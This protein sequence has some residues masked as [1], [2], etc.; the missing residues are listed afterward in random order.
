MSL[1]RRW[2]VAVVVLIV[3][4][5]LYVSRDQQ[6]KEGPRVSQTEVQGG[7][8]PRTQ[9]T[10]VRSEADREA[11]VAVAPSVAGPTL[12]QSVVE[13][14]IPE[15]DDDVYVTGTVVDPQGTPV[16]GALVRFVPVDEDMEK[17]SGAVQGM[18]MAM[19][20]MGYI[21]HET[22]TMASM[23]QGRSRGVITQA[24]GRFKVRW[25][26]KSPTDGNNS[27]R[28]GFGPR[29]NSMGTAAVVITGDAAMGELLSLDQWS[30]CP[31][32]KAPLILRSAHSSFLPV[33]REVKP[34]DE[35]TMTLMA[36]GGVRCHVQ[37]ATGRPLVGVSVRPEPKGFNMR[38]IM[39]TSQSD[40]FGVCI[41]LLPAGPTTLTFED[42]KHAPAK[43]EINVPDEGLTDVTVAMSEGVF[44]TGTLVSAGGGAVNGAQ[45]MIM[46]DHRKGVARFNMNDSLMIKNA[47]SSHDGTFSLGPYSDILPK[48]CILSVMHPQHRD[49]DMPLGENAHLGEIELT[50]LP[51]S[52]VKVVDEVG[53]PVAGAR[54]SAEWV[55]DPQ[56]FEA[57][58]DES[59]TA[60][61]MGRSFAGRFAQNDEEGEVTDAKGVA[62]IWGS[63]KHKIRV[64]HADYAPLEKCPEVILGKESQFITVVISKG[65]TVDFRVVDSH[66]GPLE[67]AKL[68]H[69]REEASDNMM[70]GMMTDMFE[71]M[72]PD[73][74]NEGLITDAKGHAKAEHL[75]AGKYSL[76]VTTSKGLRQK[77]ERVL[78]QAAQIDLVM[79][80]PGTFYGKVD[81][82][83]A[84]MG[85]LVG[86]KA[87]N[88]RAVIE[89]DGTWETEPLAP[90]SYRI[91]LQEDTADPMQ[92]GMA[93]MKLSMPSSDQ[94]S[95]GA[96]ERKF[97]D[98]MSAPVG[99]IRVRVTKANG[100]PYTDTLMA[101]G[102]GAKSG[103][104]DILEKMQ[105][106][107]STDGS[108]TYE[109]KRLP[110]GE[111]NLQPGGLQGGQKMKVRVEAGA[112]LDLQ[113]RMQPANATLKGRILTP[114]GAPA[115][116][117]VQL[118]ALEDDVP[119]SSGLIDNEG[120][121]EL[122]ELMAG[123]YE[124]R[125]ADMM[126]G[127]RR[128]ALVTLGDGAKDLGDLTLEAGV[129][130]TG[131]IRAVGGD[132]PMG[133]IVKVLRQGRII[134][135]AMVNFDGT[136]RIEGMDAGQAEVQVGPMIGEPM[137]HTTWNGR[138]TEVNLEVPG[139]H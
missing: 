39:N 119:V 31:P 103:D 94:K 80:D 40:I 50:P 97:V 101:V 2:V 98:L 86:N 92:M 127:G 42:E 124:L 129:T 126:G 52:E 113:W 12:E 8:E 51:H 4:L 22:D 64:F 117:M 41:L 110:V 23:T 79:E 73:L 62:R 89:A 37:D 6:P 83:Y 130:L 66:G 132:L 59:S 13:A 58:S 131:T 116:G 138:D 20:E 111:W 85:V 109:F 106:A 133:L 91:F 104:L 70:E 46:K 26:R 45:L 120:R 57:A 17:L 107:E 88:T 33:Q 76:A 24:D 74:N 137:A 29:R 63:G 27:R 47:I 44:V 90:G 21:Q 121:F 19:G 136:F 36:C 93:M 84:G 69:R 75:A 10:A 135:S 72:I 48:D 78:N 139:E 99:S 43:V 71:N 123:E 87:G 96:G 38:Q 9:S 118:N 7:K 11:G 60:L 105:T 49:L 55:F 32:R 3:G 134:S 54:V 108:G 15:L 35:V 122:T 81:P 18:A 28:R 53:S 95:L 1:Q 100:Q 112:R 56:S 14:L 61:R 102:L 125:T 30:Q 16:A 25:P 114:G 128:L 68:T 115:S 77:W 82:L 5:A 67:G 65:F 34:G